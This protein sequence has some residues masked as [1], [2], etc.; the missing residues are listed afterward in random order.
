[1]KNKIV[2]N[3]CVTGKFLHKKSAENKEKGGF[4]VILC[5]EYF[6]VSIMFKNIIVIYQYD[7]AFLTMQKIG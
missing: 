3:Q 1:M 7:G 4:Q 6:F 2:V 5:F